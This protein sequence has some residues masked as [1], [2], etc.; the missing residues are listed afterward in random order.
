[1]YAAPSFQPDNAPPSDPSV[2]PCA[3]PV[4]QSGDTSARFAAIKGDP[5]FQSDL[6]DVFSALNQLMRLK[7]RTY[8][9]IPCIHDFMCITNR[10]VG[11]QAAAIKN[12]ASMLVDMEQIFSIT[13]LA[14]ILA[15][16]IDS[17]QYRYHHLNISYSI[18][19]FFIFLFF[20]LKIIP[21]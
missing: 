4:R 1:M 3:L 12:F 18:L 5:Q 19:P 15:K 14:N 13:Q 16:F 21:N 20:S 10:Y 8:L 7:G 17:V 6:L 9:V 11:A 2:P